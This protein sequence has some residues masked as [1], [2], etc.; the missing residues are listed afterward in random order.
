MFL[1]P[2][3]SPKQKQKAQNDMGRLFNYM[4][5]VPYNAAPGELYT[6]ETLY[7]GF[8]P[9]DME[10]FNTCYDKQVYDYYIEKGKRTD[11]PAELMARTYHDYC[12]TQHLNTFLERY[13]KTKVVAVMGGNAMLR[14]DKAYRNIVIVSKHLTEQGTLM[15]SGG[16]SGAMEAAALGGLLAG[17]DDSVIDDALQM[18]SVAPC[19]SSKGYLKSSYYVLER[20]PHIG[21]YEMLTIPTWLYGHESTTPFA[22]HIA[23]YFDNSIREDMLL[24]ISY[25]GIIFTPGSAGTMQEVFQD[26]T[27]NHYLTYGMASPMIFMDTNFWTQKIPAFPFLQMLSDT[28]RYKNMLLSLTDDPDEVIKIIQ[29]YASSHPE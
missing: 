17:Y 29:N 26:A 16:G 25:G 6:A 1:T 28:G 18:L 22:T 5:F 12:I 8:D 7:Q 3:N 20:Y 24:T 15:I 10:T 13:P 2:T 19:Y 21:E 9:A 4:S 11:D 23:K 14:T 27:Q